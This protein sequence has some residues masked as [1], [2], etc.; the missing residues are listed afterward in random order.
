MSN[1][2][3]QG[4]VVRL[5]NRVVDPDGKRV[6]RKYMVG[7]IA[8]W[9]HEYLDVPVEYADLIIHQSM[10]KIDPVNSR[11][12]YRLGCERFGIPMA[13][14]PVAETE[15]DE[16]IDR[17]LLSPQRQ[18]AKP[19]RFHNPIRRMDRLKISDPRDGDGAF[20]GEFGNRK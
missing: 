5:V 2:F 10:Y 17:T 15:R 1:P 6:P 3:S 8:F 4:A 9:I 20:A 12:H 16:L 19:T 14:V 7:G 13:D 11:G 18:K